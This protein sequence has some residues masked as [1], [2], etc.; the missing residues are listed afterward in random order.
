VLSAVRYLALSILVA[1]VAALL[2][3]PTLYAASSA[4]IRSGGGCVILVEGER[5]T[6]MCVSHHAVAGSGSLQLALS[7]SN[8]LSLSFVYTPRGYRPSNSSIS[9]DLR[10]VVGGGYVV[11]RIVAQLANGSRVVA[12]ESVTASMMISESA[13]TVLS[14]VYT[15]E[16]P[17][18]KPVKVAP[19]NI[20]PIILQ[21]LR[22]AGISYV[23]SVGSAYLSMN[24]SG[25]AL[26]MEL[27]VSSMV[28]DRS[29]YC[30]AVGAACSALATAEGS[31]ALSLALSRGAVIARLSASSTTSV[32]SVVAAM[33]GLAPM[34]VNALRA[35]VS[36]QLP[37][38]LRELV[39]TAILAKL[40]GLLSSVIEAEAKP[41]IQLIAKC[42]ELNVTSLQAT[43]MTNSSSEAATMILSSPSIGVYGPRAVVAMVY[44]YVRS[45]GAAQLCG[46]QYL[47]PLHAQIINATSAKGAASRAAVMGLSP[48]W[49]WVLWGVIALVVGETAFIAYTLVKLRRRG[50]W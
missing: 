16:L 46:A 42:S 14:A 1:T 34:A 25:H 4:R 37:P 8:I 3:A 49:L 39:A 15:L 13:I 33:L 11:A 18:K 32:G 41:L 9:L 6:W 50:A 38:I 29:A 45:M 28:I 40:S 48:T 44:Q 22:A 43:I 10:A 5:A 21:G 19:T 2:G 17:S 35:F 24:S 47:S 30:S 31:L 27:S 23:K 7:G 26:I 36:S 20:A 12:R